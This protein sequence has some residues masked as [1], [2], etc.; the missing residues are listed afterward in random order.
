MAFIASSSRPCSH[1][2]CFGHRYPYGGCSVPAKGLDNEGENG[3]ASH[4]LY[5]KY[6]EPSHRQIQH[7]PPG[8][9][10]PSSIV[11]SL[12]NK[13]C[14]ACQ[15]SGEP[16]GGAA[17]I[18]PIRPWN[19]ALL[20]MRPRHAMYVTV[21]PIRGKTWG[22]GHLSFLVDANVSTFPGC[23]SLVLELVQPHARCSNGPCLVLV[24][25]WDCACCHLLLCCTSNPI[26]ASQPVTSVL[27]RRTRRYSRG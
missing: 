26:L 12:G 21:R 14:L 11:P 2:I 23:L 13:Q 17:A 1:A 7:P 16:S 6:K 9:Q 18:L 8:T 27:S 25:R 19:A 4:V 10:H 24:L 3:Q 5:Y 15:V 20:R 22:P